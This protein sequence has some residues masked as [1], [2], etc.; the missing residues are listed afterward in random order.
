MYT[1]DPETN[2]GRRGRKKEEKLRLAVVNG[3]TRWASNGFGEEGAGVRARL[4]SPETLPQNPAGLPAPPGLLPPTVRKRLSSGEIPHVTPAMMRRLTW[5]VTWWDVYRRLL[6]Y[7]VAGMRLYWK[8]MMDRV[9]RGDDSMEQRGVRLREAI[10]WVGGTAV[11]LG[12][13]A[14]MRIDLMPYA[15]T[16]ELSK[17]LDRMPAF[18]VEQAIER[19]E[20]SLKK[21][22]SEVFSR[23]EPNPIGSASVSCVYEAYLPDGTRVAIK[24]RRPGIGR[25]FIADCDA[26]ALVMR[27]LEFFTL[28]KPGLAHNFLFEFRT[29][30]LEELDFMKEARYTELFRRRV[31]KHMEHLSAPRVFTDYNSDNVMVM[32]FVAGIWLRELIVAVERK[33]EEALALLREQGIS[34]EVVA[35]RL[36]RANQYG[37]FE[38]VLFHADPHPSNVVVQK[39][40]RLVFIDFGS[41]GAYTTRERNNWRQLSYYH[42]QEDIGRMVQSALA[43]LE[44]LPPIDIDEFS[45]RL[46]M[47]FWQ[48]LYAFKSKHSEWWEH[49]SAKIWINFME[50]SR[51]YGIPMNLNTLRMIRSTLLYETIAARLYKD[52]SAYREHR[53]YNQ[54]AG[55]RARKRV[56]KKVHRWMF[57]GLRAEDY[58]QVEQLMDMGNRIVYLAQRYLDTPPY[59]FS[60]LIDKAVFALT[61]TLR[62][63]LGFVFGTLLL[64]FIWIS[65][66]V[67]YLGEPL[68][69]VDLAATC[70]SVVSWRPFQFLIGTFMFLNIR[71]VLFRFFDKDVSSSGSGLK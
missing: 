29:M 60:L 32:E 14:A 55:K 47:V 37:I 57:R 21:P 18:P 40:G 38:N 33:D 26:L 56:K 67:F 1:P 52:V 22:I 53:K 10:E 62:G 7:L 11:K 9:V 63:I 30:L 69:Q 39:G 64:S 51:Q 65:Y 70:L 58:L 66:R 27:V 5:K 23:F 25:K 19:I 43:I 36:L 54:S 49:T 34:P 31:R 6:V 44:P 24:V 41:C 15:Y 42:D 45:K 16:V 46:E 20:K 35:R 4:T 8:W 3:V 50:L 12:Q 13:Q 28:I 61:V 48:D 17:M 71:R 2:P 59:R 68:A